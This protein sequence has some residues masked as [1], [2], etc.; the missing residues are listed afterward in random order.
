MSAALVS[1]V[2][3]ATAAVHSY[4]FLTDA[5]NSI[6]A[7]AY[8]I[9]LP[10]SL[11][12]V[13]VGAGW[14]LAQRDMADEHAIRVVAW[15]IA[16]AVAFTIPSILMIRYQQSEGVVMSNGV[17]AL[18]NGTTGG[19]AI[20]FAFGL[21]ASRI[22]RQ[23]AQ[24]DRYQ[25]RLERERDRFVALFDNLPDPAV[26]YEHA[27]DTPV[28]RVVNPAFERTFDADGTTV[29]GTPVDEVLVPTDQKN[30]SL[31]L[32]TALH[33][34]EMLQ[35]EIR[36]RT[37]MG[38][39]NF[40]M[41]VIPPQIPPTEGTGHI[42]A[43]DVTERKQYM[44]RL[45]VL[46][47]VLRHDL[48]NH[49]G[50]IVGNSDLLI[51][52]L[53]ETRKVETIRET[54]YKLV[55][56][57]ETVQQIEHA[58]DRSSETKGTVALLDVLGEC[59]DRAH[60]EYPDADIRTEISVTGD[61]PVTAN[62]QID[63]VFDNVIENAIEHNDATTPVVSITVTDDTCGFVTVEIADNGP[64]LP[65]RERQVLEEGTETQ[66]KHSLGLGLWFVNWLIVDSGGDVTFD[67]NDPHGSIVTIDLPKADNDDFET[68]DEQI[69]LVM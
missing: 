13:L 26:Q 39:R 37:A 45:E 15:S 55:E 60:S 41:I 10:L 44:R 24:L 48:R 46:N 47:R 21:Y 8:G 22:K 23:T 38:I 64:G 11:S 16:G 27:G 31:D 1:C 53:S 42:I 40:Q 4:H 9:V 12:L 34:D 58:L 14:W 57:G 68:G 67:D 17:F 33:S 5:P 51:E 50:V 59:V 25:R 52:E 36:L 35:E 65:D 2:G 62:K 29:N 3:V 32:N 43:V 20:G 66:L 6:P 28:V 61:T 56:L 49:A 69:S 54:A 7:L 30:V 18:T 63:T 19:M